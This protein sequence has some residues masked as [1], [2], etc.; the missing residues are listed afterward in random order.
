MSETL[1][2][3]GE[4][5]GA[6]A[7]NALRGLLPLPLPKPAPTALIHKPQRNTATSQGNK[8]KTR[9]VK[10]GRVVKERRDSTTESDEATGK[11]TAD[12]AN[13]LCL[14]LRDRVNECIDRNSTC[15][16]HWFLHSVCKIGCI[17]ISKRFILVLELSIFYTTFQPLSVWDISWM[18]RIIFWWNYCHGL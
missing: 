13:K 14:N 8:T 1:Q 12:I 5:P 7:V 2:F 18:V 10:P 16:R 15:S 4:Y 17:G 3:Q 6:A 11:Q 9:K